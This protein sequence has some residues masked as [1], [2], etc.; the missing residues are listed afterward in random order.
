MTESAPAAGAGTEV[1]VLYGH[2]PSKKNLYR[3]ARN[4]RMF[5]DREVSDQIGALTSHAQRQWR[6]RRPLENPDIEVTLHVRNGR[7][8]RDNKWT[9][10]SDVLQEAGVLV[11]DNIARCN[12]TIILRPCVISA[13][14]RAFIRLTPRQ[15]TLGGLG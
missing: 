6:G 5:L 11:N 7:G 14:E 13:S 12:G 10:I 4:G 2:V 3:R 9:T 1:I 15:A 8:D